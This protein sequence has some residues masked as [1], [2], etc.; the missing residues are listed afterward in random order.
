MCIRDSIETVILSSDDLNKKIIRVKSD[1]GN[2]FG[3]RLDK[4]Q[5]LQNG[6]AFFIDDHHVLAIGVESQDLIVISPKDMDEMGITAHILGN[7]HKPIEVKDA[8]IYLE[9]DPVVEQVLTQKEI[10]YTIEEVVLDKPLRH[11]N[12]TAHEH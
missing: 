8:K 11:V 7:T 2:E 5:K 10:A 3:I 6:S 4:G 9:V 12:L 1:H